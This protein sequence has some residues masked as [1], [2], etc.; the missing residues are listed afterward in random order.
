MNTKRALASGVLTLLLVGWSA[1]ANGQDAMKTRLSVS[2]QGVPVATVLQ[3]LAAVIGARLQIDP[4]L[5]GSVTLEVRNV[6]A[7]TALRAVCE[8]VGCR[9]RLD[10]GRLI[11]DPDPAANSRSQPDPYADIKLSDIHQDIPAHIV[12]SAAPLDAVAGALARMLD[13]QLILD[14]ALAAKRVTLDQ[15]QGSAWTAVSGV[16]REAGCRWRFEPQAGRRLLLVADSPAAFGASLPADVHRVGQPGVTAPRILNQARPRYTEA[17]RK[18]GLAGSVQIECVVL[19]D[20]TVGQVHILKSLDRIHGL[21][22]EAVMAAKLSL[23]SPGTVN[24]TPAPV[25]ALI[26]AAFSA[27]R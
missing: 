1:T 11:V 15:D 22:M 7:E 12:W 21:D 18:A 10:Q 4:R 9:W 16:C 17:A 24:G 13:A 8:S 25:V 5:A 23:F 19:P 3:A 27:Y 14:P 2:Y 26:G 6:T 20:G